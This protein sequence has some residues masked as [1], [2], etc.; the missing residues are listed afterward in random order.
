MNYFNEII[1]AEGIENRIHVVRGHKIILDQDLACLYGVQTKALN[2]A[3]NRNNERFPEDFAFQLSDFEW[4]ILRSQIV[5]SKPGR[6]GRRYNPYAFTEHGVVMAANILKSKQAIR[7]SIQVVRVF[8]Q[9]RQLIIEHREMSKQLE[10]LK[11]FVLKN[12]SEN[13][14]EI[15]KIWTAIEKL[16]NPPMAQS[17]IGFNLG[18]S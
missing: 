10:E 17:R 7:I 12:T 3:V 5:T 13:R 16:Q 2:Q 15:R 4:E 18:N 14:R 11:N 6:G 9:M 1:P 8:V